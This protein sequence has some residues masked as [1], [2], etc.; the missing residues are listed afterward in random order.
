MS[1]SMAKWREDS[2]SA[3]GKVSMSNSQKS[4]NVAQADT[5]EAKSSSKTRHVCD[6]DADDDGKEENAETT[7]LLLLHITLIL[8]SVRLAKDAIESCI[9]GRML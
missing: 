4:C 6:G 1:V 9:A 8:T 7:I 3:A 5:T 2:R